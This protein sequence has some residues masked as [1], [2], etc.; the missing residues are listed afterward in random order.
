MSVITICEIDFILRL[1]SQNKRKEWEDGSNPAENKRQCRVVIFT[2][3][4][5][6]MTENIQDCHAERGGGSF[7]EEGV[8]DFTELH[9]I[10]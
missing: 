9:V 5:E 1:I 3:M 8:G 10:N 7:A 2:H 4:K 6:K